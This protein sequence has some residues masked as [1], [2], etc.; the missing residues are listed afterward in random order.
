MLY[1]RV[2]LERLAPGGRIEP[3]LCDLFPS[4]T[5]PFDLI[6]SNPP[7][8]PSAD[9]PSLMPE[10]AVYEPGIALDGGEDGLAVLRRLVPEA[11][12]RLAP[13]GWLLVEHGFDQGE[14]VR[15]LFLN[16]GGF[17]KVESIRDFGGNE[18]V[19]AGRTTGNRSESAGILREDRSDGHGI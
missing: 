5:E 1:A 9:I 3:V 8:I 11:K 17:D 13:G 14:T 10:V 12:S 6:V 18:R 2:N 7:Y 19:T 15:G 4:D 16:G